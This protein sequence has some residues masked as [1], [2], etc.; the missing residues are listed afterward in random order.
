MGSSYANLAELVDGPPAPLSKLASSTSGV[1]VD[2]QGVRCEERPDRLI[3]VSNQLPVRMKRREATDKPSAGHGWVFE[4]DEDSLVGQAKAGI[5]QPQFQPAQARA[6]PRL[7]GGT[8]TARSG[9]G[10]QDA[11]LGARRDLGRTVSCEW[12]GPLPSRSLRRAPAAPLR[13]LI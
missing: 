8:P 3:M 4:W 11:R 5:E 6:P 1:S 9:R 10:A 2:S 12:L 13:G 7:A